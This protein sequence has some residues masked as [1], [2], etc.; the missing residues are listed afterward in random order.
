[1]IYYL[2]LRKPNT[3]SRNPVMVL[4]SCNI[5][6]SIASLLW[7][8][9][10]I[11]KLVNN[12]WLD[13]LRKGSVVKYPNKLWREWQ[14]IMKK[15]AQTLNDFNFIYNCNTIHIVLNS[16]WRAILQGHKLTSY[17]LKY[18]FI[19]LKMPRICTT[20]DLPL[21]KLHIPNSVVSSCPFCSLSDFSASSPCIFILH[22][23]TK[24]S[25]CSFV[26]G[27]STSGSKLHKIN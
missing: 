21:T 10:I 5:S 18:K 13:G 16:S 7:N 20:K 3:A 8:S 23:F 17:N 12:C 25:A 15:G 2:R 22:R 1:M 14:I 6:I 4:R 11:Y 27:G 9:M 19:I 26:N 24:S